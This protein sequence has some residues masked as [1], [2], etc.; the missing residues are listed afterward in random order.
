MS[1]HPDWPERLSAFLEARRDRPF[2]WGAH[3][4]V[5]MAADWVVEATG[6]DPIDGWRGRWSSASQAARMLAQAGGVPGAVTERLGRPLESVLLAG[7]GDIGLFIHDG[8]KTLGVVT[9]AGLACPGE[10]GMVIVP[11]T[12]AEA[13]WRV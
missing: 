11:L 5:L 12:S 3:D 13:A 7:R 1:R 9:D 8:R 10:H 4:C 2:E 6:V